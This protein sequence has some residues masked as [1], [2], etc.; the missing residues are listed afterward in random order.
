MPCSAGFH[1]E[2]LPTL[3]H[4]Y[5]WRYQVDK[6]CELRKMKESFRFK[7]GKMLQV[8]Y[9]K[10]SPLVSQKATFLKYEIKVY[11]FNFWHE[12]PFY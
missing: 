12:V 5:C 10:A 6:M 3:F 4:A 7:L 2:H 1:C 11:L 8:V 9:Q